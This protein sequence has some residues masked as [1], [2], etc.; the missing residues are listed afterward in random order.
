MDLYCRFLILLQLTFKWLS[1]LLRTGFRRHLQPTDLWK[2]DQSRE[3]KHSSKCTDTLAL[4]LSAKFMANLEKRQK[5]AAEWNAKLPTA[6]PAWNLQIKW[7]ILAIFQR[8]LPQYAAY[9]SDSTYAE[10]RATLESEWRSQSGRKRGSLAWALSDTLPRF[11]WAGPYKIVG[12]LAMMMV[13]LLIKE[14]II[15]AAQGK[16]DL[17]SS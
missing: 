2:M 17:L 16:S 8:H 5:R 14:L 15:F 13:P 12:D 3:G 7:A 10:R 6:T 11:W 1:P 4:T 9:G